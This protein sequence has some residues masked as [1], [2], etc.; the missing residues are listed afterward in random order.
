[1][2]VPNLAHDYTDESVQRRGGEIPQFGASFAVY[3]YNG[4][5]AKFTNFGGFHLHQIMYI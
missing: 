5:V 2:K 4:E 3:Q 1:M